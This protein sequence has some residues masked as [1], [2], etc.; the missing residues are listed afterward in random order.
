MTATT[1]TFRRPAGIVGR[2]FLLLHL[3]AAALLLAPGAAFADGDVP[4]PS[5]QAPD[6]VKKKVD[7][8]LGLLLYFGIAAVVA[9]FIMA[10]IALAVG[11]DGGRG[12]REGTQKLWFAAGGAVVIGSASAL[13]GFFF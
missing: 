2:A 4:N 6:D 13:A 10:G 3:A 11:H 9:G 5:P 12:G 1:T 8:M 7:L